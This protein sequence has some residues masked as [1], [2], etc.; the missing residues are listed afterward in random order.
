MPI[1]MGAAKPQHSQP[2]QAK[3][4]G[5]AETQIAPLVALPLEELI[6][7]TLPARPRLLGPWLTSS[8]LVMVHARTGVGKT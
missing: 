7:V 4:N 6:K 5:Q 8:S 2:D 3:P 1:D